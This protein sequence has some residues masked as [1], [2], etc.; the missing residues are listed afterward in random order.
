VCHTSAV[1]PGTDREAGLVAIA[2][3]L[4]TLGADA[5][6]RFPWRHHEVFRPVLWGA[7]NVVHS[8][9]LARTLLE[10]GADPSDGVTL[11]I[12]AS[13]GDLAALDL[14][15]AFGV[16][17]NGPWATDGSTALY[18]MLHWSLTDTGAHWLI[19]HGA[20]VD[21]VNA[22]NGETPLHV[23][24]ARWTVPLAAALVDRGAEVTR[25]RADGRT[26]YAIARLSGNDTVADWL[27]AHGAPDEVSAVDRLVGLCSRGDVAAARA[28]V[29]A[30]PEL[31]GAIG[32]EH[33]DAFYQAA[34]R[35]DVHA[36]EAMLACGFD[37]NRGD[38]AMDMNALH[39]AA[40]AGWPEAVR[41][42]LA[43]GASVQARDREFHAT[44]LV[45]AAEGSRHAAPDRDHAAVGR[46][47]LDAG[48]PVDWAGSAEPSEEI[49]EII[50]DWTSAR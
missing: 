31:T 33:Y 34:E 24:A 7:V 10:A 5:N 19:E 1:A 25:R 28:M 26:P 40:M 44:A 36:L 12:A 9:P 2:R 29:A 6:L 16:D 50:A 37:P 38:E 8:L 45:A 39:K 48:S 23:V 43:N 3:R 22:A 46:L 20:D 17:P 49:L 11:T 41:V 21:R 18:A 47:L 15:H 4:L 35:N 13:A 27:L 32:P 42:L 30:S 14:L